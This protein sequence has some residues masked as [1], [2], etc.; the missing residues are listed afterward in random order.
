MSKPNKPARARKFR[1]DARRARAAAR[2]A[3]D[4]WYEFELSQSEPDDAPALDVETLADS[5]LDYAE[6]LAERYDY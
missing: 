4:A 3:S 5:A 1:D 2:R 6:A